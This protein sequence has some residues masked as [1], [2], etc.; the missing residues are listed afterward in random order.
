MG[1]VLARLGAHAGQCFFWATHGGAELDLLVVRGV[2]RFGFEFK[3]TAAP[4]LTASMHVALRDLK[5]ECLDV[6]YPGS[7]TFALG[8]NVRAMGLSSVLRD[9][10]PL[11]AEDA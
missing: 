8:D 11:D 7:Q 6:V 9:L 10:Q 2:R 4:R 1:E 3:H 5:L